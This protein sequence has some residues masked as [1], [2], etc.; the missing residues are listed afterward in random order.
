MSRAAQAMV[1]DDAVDLVRDIFERVD[2]PLEMLEDLALTMNRNGSFGP[3]SLNARLR[4][5]AM[6]L[7]GMA[8]HPHQPLGRARAAARRCA[9][10]SRSSGMASA[11]ST[12]GD[13]R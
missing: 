5:A 6:D 1:D 4:P 10:T 2:D 12:R 7:V 11:A 3:S 8:F 13:R 9:P